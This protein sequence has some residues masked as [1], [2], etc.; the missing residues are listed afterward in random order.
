MRV[1]VSGR[2]LFQSLGA[3][4]LPPPMIP[5]ERVERANVR[6][7]IDSPCLYFLARSSGVWSIGGEVEEEV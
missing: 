3:V 2:S 4:P 6:S 7:L 5:E 1:H